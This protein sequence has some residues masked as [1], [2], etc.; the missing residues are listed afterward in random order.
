[1]NKSGKDILLVFCPPRKIYY[2]PIEIAYIAT[3]IKLQ[4]LTVEICDLNLQLYRSASQNQRCLWQKTN[5]HLWK[6]REKVNR[7]FERMKVKIDQLVNN[8]LNSHTTIIYLNIEYPNEY[9]SS[10][11]IR[12]LKTQKPQLTIIAGGTGCCSTEQRAD[13][14][15]Q[16]MNAID[17]FVV[18]DREKI[19]AEIIVLRCKPMYPSN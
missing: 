14:I 13:L 7:L 19:V 4:G 16:S 1:M 12:I 11:L 17:F 5:E 10:K 8:M 6:N 15:A 18:G 9:F 2:P 3:N